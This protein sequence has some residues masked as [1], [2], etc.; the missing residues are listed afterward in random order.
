MD[1]TGKISD[2]YT[3][4]GRSFSIWNTDDL[5]LVYD[6]GSDIERK[7]AEL[8]PEVFNS[9]IDDLNHLPTD[10]ADVR[11]DDMVCAAESHHS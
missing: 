1:D 6:S 7:H 3:F 5:S 8:L 10:D 9:H 11:S 4:V 2:L